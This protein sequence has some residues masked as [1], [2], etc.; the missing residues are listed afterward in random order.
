ML[1]ASN[2]PFIRHKF[3]FNVALTAGRPRKGSLHSDIGSFQDRRRPWKF[4]DMHIPETAWDYTA[5]PSRPY[6]PSSGAMVSNRYMKASFPDSK[7]PEP[8]SCNWRAWGFAPYWHRV[9]LLRLDS[10]RRCL[11][12]KLRIRMRKLL[13]FRSTR[14]DNTSTVFVAECQ[15]TSRGLWGY[16]FYD[17]P[18]QDVYRFIQPWRSGQPKGRIAG[19]V[20]EFIEWG[21][22]NNMAYLGSLID[23]IPR[24][25]EKRDRSGP[26]LRL[27]DLHTSESPWAS[28]PRVHRAPFLEQRR[29]IANISRDWCAIP[30]THLPAPWTCDWS[31]WYGW[32]RGPQFFE[33]ILLLR[34]KLPGRPTV[35]GPVQWQ[36]VSRVIN[37]IM[38]HTS[39]TIFESGGMFYL[40][41]R[42]DTLFKF[43]GSYT[44]VED[45]MDN[46]DWNLMRSAESISHLVDTVHKPPLTHSDR[47]GK[48]NLLAMTKPDGTWSFKGHHYPAWSEV[49]KRRPPHAASWPA[50]TNEQLPAP[51]SCNWTI[52]EP[53]KDWYSTD[54]GLTNTQG[55]LRRLWG[56]PGL[57][58]VV[59]MGPSSF[60]RESPC[61]KPFPTVLHAGE[62]YYLWLYQMDGI[63][64][65]L[66][67][68]EGTYKSVEDFMENADWNGLSEPMEQMRD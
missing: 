16:Y 46:C 60:D 30:D 12:D 48:R 52:F 22:W 61:T 4:W 5:R 63:K 15:K 33:D 32:S 42:E 21:D 66:R 56:V 9:S 8:W 67:K 43:R 39:A 31:K 65:W 58:P 51:F 6:P 14:V 3:I 57:T 10:L 47:G 40:F 2:W 17:A 11:E 24:P 23:F 36:D 59:Y 41:E 7:F 64:P 38:F 37:P 29:M 35:M 53:A 20:E 45:F 49:P 68:F 27:H 25:K 55:A 62:M 34:Y 54:I 1:L 19:S 50:M 13:M 18:T 44:S 28:E 26:V